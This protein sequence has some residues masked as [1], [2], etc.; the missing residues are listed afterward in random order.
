MNFERNAAQ[1]ESIPEFSPA[2][3]LTLEER[4]DALKLEKKGS[5]N[6]VASNLYE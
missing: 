2:T 5:L 4:R 3:K 6:T 1:I